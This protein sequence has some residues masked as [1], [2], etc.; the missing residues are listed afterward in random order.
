MDAGVTKGATDDPRKSNIE[1]KWN[2]NAVNDEDVQRDS[3]K[4]VKET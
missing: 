1:P 3:E 2:R 4:T